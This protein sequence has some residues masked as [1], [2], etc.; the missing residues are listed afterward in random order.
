M[1]K[2]IIRK[3]KRALAWTFSKR[4]GEAIDS[5]ASYKKVCAIVEEEADKW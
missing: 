3:F 4:V 2:K 1:L 5:G